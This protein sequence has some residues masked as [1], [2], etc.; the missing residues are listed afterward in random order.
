MSMGNNVQAQVGTVNRRE[1]LLEEITTGEPLVVS[2]C[3]ED[4]N[5]CTRRRRGRHFCRLAEKD[6]F[7]GSACVVEV[8]GS[9]TPRQRS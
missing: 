2:S 1:G 8:L 9:L 5:S 6:V 7:P 3:R 4:C